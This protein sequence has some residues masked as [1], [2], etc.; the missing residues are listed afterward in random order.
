MSTNNDN[1]VMAFVLGAAVG[2]LAALLLAPRSGQETRRRLLETAEDLYE[3]GEEKVKEVTSDVRER[4]TEVGETVK[5]RVE[6]AT[7]GAR[8]QVDAVKEAASEAKHTYQKERRRQ[9]AR[10]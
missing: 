9:E 2:G 10:G 6:G 5:D 8:S 3:T 1:T 7:E 4:A